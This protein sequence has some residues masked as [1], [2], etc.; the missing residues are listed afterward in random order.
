MS[1]T[2]IIQDRLLEAISTIETTNTTGKEEIDELRRIVSNG[3]SC[4]ANSKAKARRYYRLAY[5]FIL[6]K[7]ENS[8]RFKQVHH[9]LKL[10]LEQ[11]VCFPSPPPPPSFHETSTHNFFHERNYELKLN[12]NNLKNK[13][14]IP[15]ISL[16]T[17]FSNKKINVSQRHVT[18]IL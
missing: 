13:L 2:T 4:E 11:L 16:K 12:K 3:I 10:K 17:L 5:E 1:N 8:K 9:L 15:E 6:Q 7:G 18:Q 14:F